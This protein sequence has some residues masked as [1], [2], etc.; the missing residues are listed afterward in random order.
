MARFLYVGDKNQNPSLVHFEHGHQPKQWAA[1]SYCWGTDHSRKL[2][3]SSLRDLQLGIALN[4]L[5]A[6][7]R[8]AISITRAL[9]IDYLWVDALCIL[10]D[11]LKQDWTLQ[12][13]QMREIY[14]NST[15]TLVAADSISVVQGF[16][17]L[18]NEHD[19]PLTWR[20]D[21]PSSE[22]P[23]GGHIQQVYVSKSR[24][25]NDD[26]LDGPWTNRGWTFQESLL[27]NR[28]L[29]YSSS[30][31]V[32][33]CCQEIRYE[34]G[35]RHN[36]MLEVAKEFSDEGGRNFWGFDLFTKFK[37]MHWYLDLLGNSIARSQGK[38]RLWYE[39]VEGYSSRQLK[40][41]SDRLVAI[42]GL[43][44]R[45]GSALGNDQ[46]LMG[47]WRADIIRGLLWRVQEEKLLDHWTRSKVFSKEFHAPS[48]T[49]VGVPLGSVIRNDHAG[50]VD[51]NPLATVRD[52]GIEHLGSP[53]PFEVAHNGIINLHGPTFRFFKLYHED[54]QTP[55]TA[56]SAFERHLSR[57]IEDEYLQRAKEFSHEG[58]YAAVL[59]LQ[60]LV[61]IDH[62]IDV[63]ILEAVPVAPNA[64][65]TTFKRVG[66]FKLVYFADCVKASPALVASHKKTVN[67]LQNRLD[68]GRGPRRVRFIDCRKVFEE[69]EVN[70]W[71]CETL[72][73]V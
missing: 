2:T 6:T 21:D 40:Y 41:H 44:A 52:A 4:E 8:D 47:L 56:L 11:G 54:W 51:F 72:A 14:E 68:P 62:R 42:S 23:C 26:K 29:F 33:K 25:P 48:W 64:K 1:L 10:Q 46:Y 32:W 66:V 57:V 73:I 43:A 9:G 18:R 37:L 69:L 50:V 31:M 12:A 35:N 13:S 70:M 24:C 15:I 55:A 17:S 22:S 39:L 63:L 60:H 30:Q 27:P 67:S 65:P 36:P 59:M 49:W 58:N 45:Y 3:T 71:H 38:Y 16:L 53:N 5:D 34:R 7:I 61:A 19:V 20:L 28:L